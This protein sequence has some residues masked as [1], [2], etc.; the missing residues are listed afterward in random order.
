MHATAVYTHHRLR[1]KRRGQA[2][3][4]GYLTTYQLV[5]LNLIGCSDD[6]AIAIVDF[7]L[8]RR[9]FGMV[10]LILEAHGALHFRSRID[11]CAQE[12]AGQ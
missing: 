5:E 3:V 4:G 1:Q 12:V 8:R 9:N 6:L 7:K 2:H 10:L 11:E